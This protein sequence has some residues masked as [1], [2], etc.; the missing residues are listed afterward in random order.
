MKKNFILFLLMIFV[1]TAMYAGT[2]VIGT[3]QVDRFLKSIEQGTGDVP[4]TTPMSTGG[5]INTDYAGTWDV[6]PGITCTPQDVIGVSYEDYSNSSDHW[7]GITSIK[8][9]NKGYNQKAGTEINF[10]EPSTVDFDYSGIPAG[11]TTLS[12]YYDS[13]DLAWLD[14]INLSGNNFNNIVIDGGPYNAMPLSIVDLSNNPNLTTLSIVNCTGLVEVNL[15]GTGLTPA[16]FQIV[17]ADILASSPTANIINVAT[18]VSAITSANL[19]KVIVK[20]NYIRIE[21]KKANDVVKI[22]NASGQKLIETTEES[23]NA[24]KYSKGVYIVKIN[25]FV[26]KIRI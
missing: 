19:P 20:D 4:P 3:N 14:T 12:S 23:I 7:R 2:W 11:Y 5:T 24:G 6:F 10:T 16:A 22:F 17:K 9:P 8:Y 15:S 26:T 1:S 18:G 13:N 21:N 25:S